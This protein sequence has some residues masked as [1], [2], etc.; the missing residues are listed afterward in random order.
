MKSVL[1]LSSSS[2]EFIFF[3]YSLESTM[4]HFGSSIDEFKGDFFMSSS[5]NL[6]N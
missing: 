4:S 6:V 1:S 3:F 5:G 2:E